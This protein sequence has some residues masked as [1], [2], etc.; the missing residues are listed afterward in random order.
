MKH[1]LLIFLLLFPPLILNAEKELSDIPVYPGSVLKSENP[2]VDSQDSLTGNI[3]YYYEV[4]ADVNKVYKWFKTCEIKNK[5]THTT[6]S[7]DETPIPPMN[8]I[9]GIVFMCFL[10]VSV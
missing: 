9:L 7:S 8:T 1:L 3:S 10:I 6:I 4:K 2:D 5:F